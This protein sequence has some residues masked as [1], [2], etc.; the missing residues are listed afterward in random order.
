MS[1]SVKTR[2]S[3]HASGNIVLN[4]DDSQS[5]PQS[6]TSSS[7]TASMTSDIGPYSTAN[8]P[9]RLQ[10]PAAVLKIVEDFFESQAVL[11][12]RAAK[13]AANKEAAV[14]E[15]QNHLLAGTFP[16]DVN[17]K[18]TAPD[19]LPHSIPVEVRDAARVE[20][21]AAFK[22][23]QTAC[24]SRRLALLENDLKE[25]QTSSDALRQTREQLEQAIIDVGTAANTDFRPFMHTINSHVILYLAR[26]QEIHDECASRVAFRQTRAVAKK[27][28][29][30]LQPAASEGTAAPASAAA[31]ATEPT[32]AEIAA[33][34]TKVTATMAAMQLRLATMQPTA[35]PAPAVNK[36]PRSVAHVVGGPAAKT[37]AYNT[38][39]NAHPSRQGPKNASGSGGKS[40]A[41]Q[42]RAV[43]QDRN[44][45]ET[46]QRRNDS[47]DRYHDDRRRRYD[48]SPSPRPS[49][50]ESSRSKRQHS[51]SR[52]RDEDRSR[53]KQRYDHSRRSSSRTSRHDHD[54][55]TDRDRSRPRSSKHS[56]S[57]GRSSERSRL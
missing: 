32:N 8:L 9:K 15:L 25:A 29:P 39:R 22:A 38:A 47:R 42:S 14:A 28:P 51:P 10:T 13:S 57:R 2:S 36:T 26:M 34:L 16:Q 11:F 33:A 3:D 35:T 21:V 20:D 23:F 19:N 56:D 53:S 6:S 7:S 27:G 1:S 52:D 18:F 48:T 37:T 17:M 12:K 24:V 31:A 43:Y 40:T 54:R 46:Q 50:S 45:R 4:E 30:P 5:V 55:D 41:T 44:S 49:R